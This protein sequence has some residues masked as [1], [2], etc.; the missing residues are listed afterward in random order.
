MVGTGGIVI[1][2]LVQHKNDLGADGSFR[3]V[4][5][6]GLLFLLLAMLADTVPELAGPFAL[7]VLLSVAVGR[8]AVISKIVKTGSS[9]APKKTK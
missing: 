7:L 1:Y 8:E 2:D 9:P 6:L 5:S 4:W 3:A